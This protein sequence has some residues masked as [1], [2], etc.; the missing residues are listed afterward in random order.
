MNSEQW[1][2]TAG[3]DQQIFFVLD[4]RPL[5][6][7][8]LLTSVKSGEY[9]LAESINN[10]RSRELFCL[11]RRAAHQALVQAG[12]GGE[13]AIL[14][15]AGGEPR[16]PEGYSGSISHTALADKSPVAVAAV[17][18]GRVGIGVDLEGV[19][20]GLSLAVGKKTA[21]DEEQE[22]IGESGERLLRL[23]SAKE[24]LYKALYPLTKRYFGFLA[25]RLTPTSSGFQGE[26]VESLSERFQS[27]FQ[28][29]IFQE[30]RSG[31]ILSWVVIPDEEGK[32]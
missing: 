7:A 32:L 16:F 23:V 2:H 5:S 20:R 6:S 19:D 27:G 17:A 30:I 4:R 22:W 15:G 3:P 28:V 29:A 25:A 13:G 31:V 12:Y 8:P 11:G 21:F 26:L 14:R 24:A 10:L 18:K 9:R 1:V